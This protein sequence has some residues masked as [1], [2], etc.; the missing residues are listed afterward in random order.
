MSSNE[1]RTLP[2][3]T[4]ERAGG[5]RFEKFL[6]LLS[7]RFKDGRLFRSILEDKVASKEDFEISAE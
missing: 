6:G 3:E 5:E 1:I 7:E 2:K 4:A